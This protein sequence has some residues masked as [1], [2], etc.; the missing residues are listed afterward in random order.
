MDVIRKLTTESRVYRR[1]LQLGDYKCLLCCNE[2]FDVRYTRKARLEEHLELHPTGNF[3]LRVVSPIFYLGDYYHGEWFIPGMFYSKTH[4]KIFHLTDNGKFI[5][6]VGE[7][8]SKMIRSYAEYPVEDSL[9]QS[10]NFPLGG[11]D[12]AFTDILQDLLSS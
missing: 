6:Y 11:P 7:I 12:A 8:S 2:D 5:E 9:G 3:L 1:R 4:D 10:I